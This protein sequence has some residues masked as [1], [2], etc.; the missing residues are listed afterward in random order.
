MQLSAPRLRTGL[1]DLAIG[2]M[3]APVVDAARISNDYVAM[4]IIN[5]LDYDDLAA[6]HQ[7]VRFSAPYERIEMLDALPS[8]RTKPTRFVKT[9]R[10]VKLPPPNASATMSIDRKWFEIDDQALAVIDEPV[11]PEG[12]PWL[13]LAISLAVATLAVTIGLAL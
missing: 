12:R 9:V 4:E 3:A 13:W 1:D 6:T 10:V 8:I 7:F 11:V 5:D 2:T